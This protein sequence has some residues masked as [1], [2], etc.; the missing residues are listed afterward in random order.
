MAVQLVHDAW[1]E[2]FECA[3]VVSN[4]ADLCR[5]LKI[6]KQFRKKKVFLY[7]PGAPVRKPLAVLRQWSHKQIPI[8]QADLIKA[9]LPVT[10]PDTAIVKPTS[11]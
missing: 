11:W 6:V 10:I 4:D 7:T 8:T 5:A 3:A 1:D 9:Q 2:Q